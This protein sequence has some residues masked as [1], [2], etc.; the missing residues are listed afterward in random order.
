MA[1]LTVNGKIVSF[2]LIDQINGFSIKGNAE[3][4]NN[5]MAKFL[6]LNSSK[7]ENGVK[8]YEPRAKGNNNIPEGELNISIAEVKK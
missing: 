1:S 5:Y 2:A 4:F 6:F 8:V 3:Q 7:T